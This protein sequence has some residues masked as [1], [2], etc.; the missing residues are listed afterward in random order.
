MQYTAPPNQP[1]YYAQVWDFVRQ[2]P[3]TTGAPRTITATV[4]SAW[5]RRASPLKFSFNR[6]ISSS[7]SD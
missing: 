6:L 4:P 2:V 5:K 7:P 1:I 3:L